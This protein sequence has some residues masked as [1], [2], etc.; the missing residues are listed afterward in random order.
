MKFSRRN[1]ELIF[2]KGLDEISIGRNCSKMGEQVFVNARSAGKATWYNPDGTVYA[3]SD[4]PEGGGLIKA[5][6]KPGMFVLSVRAG[7]KRNFKFIV[8]NN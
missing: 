3:E 1:D 6:D 7:L 4:L 2:E 8:F 5:P